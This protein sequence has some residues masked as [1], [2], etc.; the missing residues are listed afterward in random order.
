MASNKSV[1]APTREVINDT[2]QRGVGVNMV[3]RIA[4]AIQTQNLNKYTESNPS[5]RSRHAPQASSSSST[6]ARATRT[7]QSIQ[8]D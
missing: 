5:V 2:F 8:L 7:E 1:L 3:N 4:N 6:E